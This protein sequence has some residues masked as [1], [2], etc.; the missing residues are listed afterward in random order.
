L[1]PFLRRVLLVAKINMASHPSLLSS[2]GEEGVAHITATAAAKPVNEKNSGSALAAPSTDGSEKDVEA[3]E[4]GLQRG[5][6]SWHLQFIAIGG[7]V[8][9][10]VVSYS[11]SSG[12]KTNQ[13]SLTLSSS[14][15]AEKPLQQL[16]QS[17]V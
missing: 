13:L 9:T 4:E 1:L 10:G 17:D 16:D 11:S 6:S 5:L 8:G 3:G 15:E 12:V 14:L 2:P 7:T